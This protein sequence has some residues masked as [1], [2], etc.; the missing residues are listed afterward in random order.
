MNKIYKNVRI[1][2]NSK[3]G[4]FTIIGEPPGGTKPGELKTVIGKNAVVRSHSAIYAGCE[5]GDD[6]ETGHGIMIRENNKIGNNASVGTHTVIERD[7]VI[8]DGVR[9][10]SNVFVPEYTKIKDGAWIGPNVVMTNAKFP[11]SVHAKKFLRGP[12]VE[13]N[14]K[15]GANS[16]ILPG[17]KI[18]KNSLVGTGSVVTKDVPDNSIV[19]GNPAKKI[20]DI[21]E[22]R[23]ENGEKPY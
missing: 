4:I 1:G 12:V 3:I 23:Y 6:F 10:H 9:L 22:L 2:D 14:A 15:V 17:I 19:V 18:G 11:K 16:T 20:K 5:I 7:C 13:E 21:S 8:G